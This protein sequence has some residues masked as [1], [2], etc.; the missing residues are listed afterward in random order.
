M[1]LFDYLAAGRAILSS[2]LPVLHE[3]LTPETA[4]FCPPE[5]PS[6][7][8]AALASLLADP[9]R[10]RALGLAARAAAARYTWLERETRALKEFPSA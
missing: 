10:C 2:D 1:K 4:V 5:D 3:V 8:R 6:A 9:A 7:W